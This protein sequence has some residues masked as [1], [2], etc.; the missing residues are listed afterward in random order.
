MNVAASVAICSI[1]SGTIPLVEATPVL[2]NRMTSRSLANP[3]L[4]AGS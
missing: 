4:T 1:V 3:S 2:L